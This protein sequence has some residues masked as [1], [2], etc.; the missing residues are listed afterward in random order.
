MFSDGHSKICFSGE[1]ERIHTTE[2]CCCFGFFID[3]LV[4]RN[5]F[6]RGNLEHGDR[7]LRRNGGVEDL[8]FLC[9]TSSATVTFFLYT[10]QSCCPD[11]T[12]AAF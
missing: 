8:L 1:E 7:G 10:P 12:P 9:I 6:M 4:S 3:L 5:A 2:R 11:F